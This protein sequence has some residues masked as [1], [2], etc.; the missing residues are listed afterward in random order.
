LHGR[1]KKQ[2]TVCSVTQICLDPI[3]IIMSSGSNLSSNQ[4]RNSLLSSDF[5]ARCRIPPNPISCIVVCIDGVNA[6]DMNNL[7]MDEEH[8]AI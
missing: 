7:M 4:L 6:V 1:P 3:W 5:A 2:F 8:R